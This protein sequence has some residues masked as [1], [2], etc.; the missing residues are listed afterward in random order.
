MINYGSTVTATVFLRNGQQTNINFQWNI[1]QSVTFDV[2]GGQ[3]NSNPSPQPNAP[4]GQPNAQTNAFVQKVNSFSQV[5]SYPQAQVTGDDSLRYKNKQELLKAVNSLGISDIKA[6]A[7]IFGAFGLESEQ[8]YDSNGNAQRDTSKDYDSG[9]KGSKNVSPLNMNY[10]MLTVIGFNG[11][12]DALNKLSNIK[13][14]V[15]VLIQA[16]NYLGLEGFLNFH[17][18]G[19]TGY[20]DPKKY[21]RKYKM[22][23]YRVGLF[24]IMKK[25][26]EDQSLFNDGR[27]VWSDIPHV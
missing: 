17:R 22:T 20:N 14:T 25:Y 8:M 18:A 3:S 15:Q 5:G 23:E 6:K 19:W 4:L 27:K 10:H 7:F 9:S 16:V 1:G 24:N 26:M 13:Q 11:N 12:R 2:N 21:D